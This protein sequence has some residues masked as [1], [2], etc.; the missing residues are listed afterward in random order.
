MIMQTLHAD[1]NARMFDYYNKISLCQ[2]P[3]C[4]RSFNEEAF[5]RHQTMCTAETPGGPHAKRAPGASSAMGSGPSRM[6]SST[7]PGSGGGPTQKPRAYVWCVP[8]GRSCYCRT[9]VSE[10]NTL[11]HVIMPSCAQIHTSFHVGN[12]PVGLMQSMQ[13]SLHNPVPHPIH[14][15][16][17]DPLQL[18]CSYLCGQQY[19]SKSL[20]IHIPQCQEKWAKVQ[21]AKPKGERRALPPC[22]FDLDEPLPSSAEAIDEFNAKMFSFY[23]G[24]SLYQ[25]KGCGRSFHAE[26]Y[27]KHVARCAGAAE[28]AA[29]AAKA[30][31]A[32]PI[33][34][35]KAA[36]P[37]GYMCYLCAA[38]AAACGGPGC[39]VQ[40][41]M[42]T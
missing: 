37:S 35:P 4:G 29:A 14:Q 12:G 26:A 10:I 24:V 7:G 16:S 25:C 17:S 38:C 34:A 36:A 28:A 30:A 42:R 39:D 6:A 8:V 1:F 11:Q 32:A 31:A 41:D 18:P 19:G 27:E 13:S 20:P 40:A 33:A 2:C 23:N 5:V 15:A 22:P 9:R 3:H 21:S